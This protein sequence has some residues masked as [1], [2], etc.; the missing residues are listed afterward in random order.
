VTLPTLCLVLAV[1]CSQGKALKE[2]LLVA[3][4]SSL[5]TAAFIV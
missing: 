2:Q 5:L 3:P 4:M 1:L